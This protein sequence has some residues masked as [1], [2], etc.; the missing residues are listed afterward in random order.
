MIIKSKSQFQNYFLWVDA[1]VAQCL[2]CEHISR[3]FQPGEGPSRDLLRD[4][5]NIADGS[6]AALTQ[7]QTHIGSSGSLR[8]WTLDTEHRDNMLYFSQLHFS[9]SSSHPVTAQYQIIK[10]LWMQFSRRQY[11]SIE[12]SRII[13]LL[14]Y[15][16]S[17]IDISIFPFLFFKVY[18][19]E[20]STFLDNSIA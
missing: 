13:N 12:T 17:I 18:K 15:M 16:S 5:E 4:C 7:T 1:H 19:I 3:C 6:F 9:P 2:K 20:N 8:D 11:A 14:G 10:S